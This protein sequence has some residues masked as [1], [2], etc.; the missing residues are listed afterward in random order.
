MTTTT[1]NA[2]AYSSTC[3]SAI[4]CCGPNWTCNRSAIDEW[5]QYSV[6]GPRARDTPWP[7]SSMR[8]SALLVSLPLY[9]SHGPDGLRRHSGA[10]LSALL[11]GELATRSAC[12]HVMATPWPAF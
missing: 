8:L 5:A 10:A 6:A 3:N 1:A 12:R 2:D 11:S 4:R 7:G 9:G